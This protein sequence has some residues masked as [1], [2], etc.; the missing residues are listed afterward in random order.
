MHGRGKSLLQVV[1]APLGCVGRVPSGK[2]LACF[3]SMGF[4]TFGSKSTA[5]SLLSGLETLYRKHRCVEK[6]RYAYR[7]HHSLIKLMWVLIIC[8]RDRLFT[9][10][11]TARSDTNTRDFVSIPPINALHAKSREPFHPGSYQLMQV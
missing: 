7:K 11:A 6:R 1:L 3:H 5:L 8:T 2:L 4:Y 9:S 10:H